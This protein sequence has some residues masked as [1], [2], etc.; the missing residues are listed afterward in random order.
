MYST[1]NS[2]FHISIWINCD[3]IS[4]GLLYIPS[5]SPP[6]LWTD[7]HFQIPLIKMC[8]V[9]FLV[10]VVVAM[11]VILSAGMWRCIVW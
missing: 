10:L 7:T 6:L 9:K 5:K 1:V 8:C 3:Q 2:I 4:E 11:K